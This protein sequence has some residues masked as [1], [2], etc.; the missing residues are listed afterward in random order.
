MKTLMNKIFGA[1][2]IYAQWYIGPIE[3]ALQS[4]RSQLESIKQ[5]G[6]RKYGAASITGMFGL[7]RCR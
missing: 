3:Y 5:A 2:D 7:A 4:L 6:A 1:K